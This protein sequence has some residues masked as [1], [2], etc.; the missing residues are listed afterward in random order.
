MSLG[1][2]Q[3]A[4][5]VAA[6]TQDKTPAE[7]V[8]LAELIHPDCVRELESA[9]QQMATLFD[10]L[11]S[12]QGRVKDPV[13][14]GNRLQRAQERFGATVTNPE[15]AKSNLWD[16]VGTR[17]VLSDT[18]PAGMDKT[19]ARIADGIRSGKLDIFEFNNLHGP[20]GKPYFTP[21]HIQMMRQA[22]AESGKPLRVNESKLMDTGYT[23]ACGYLNHGNGVKGELQI[24]GPR[25]LE[26]AN[27]EHIPYDVSL[28]KPL[29]RDVPEAAKPKIQS[30]VAPIENAMSG[31]SEAQ[32]KSY[33]QYMNQSYIHARN[34]ELG[35]A[36]TP[37]RLPPGLSEDL[38][39][40]NIKRVQVA[41]YEIKA[42]YKS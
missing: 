16:A 27:V 9:K 19:A 28:G 32:K 39:A 1:T 34:Q 35:V 13:S 31:M 33:D 41:L 12:V 26:L 23:V 29:V 17:L 5:G 42:Q 14:A 38:S 21:E 25:T 30:L 15:Q 3:Q 20:G 24:I 40:E 8:K 36:S 18:S 2:S 6:K 4:K 11:G 22:A 10:G 37:P 7:M